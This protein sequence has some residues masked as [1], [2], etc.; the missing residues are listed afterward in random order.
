MSD[1]T[2]EMLLHAYAN[3]YFPMAESRHA[4]ELYWF[5]PETRGII[6]LDAFHVSQSLRKLLKK[7]PFT[8]T[9]D[10]A[11]DSVIQA[12]A[13]RDETWINDE[14]IALYSELHRLGFAHSVEVWSDALGEGQQARSEDKLLVGGLYG[15]ALGGAFFGESM[16]SA[17]PNAS[18]LALVH[19]VEQLNQLGYQLLD[20]QYVN[21]HLKQFGIQE[22]PRD[23]YLKRLHDALLIKPNA[24]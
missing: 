21:A 17:V 16:F 11:F 4:K 1:I 7:N 8:L 6:P 19:L 14:I 13:N 5:Y 22:I 20:A 10:R 18:K 2:P 9:T 15:V 3:G 24:W 23:D 12:C